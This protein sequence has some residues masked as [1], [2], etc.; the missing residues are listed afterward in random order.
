MTF[1]ESF[2]Q[3]C[4]NSCKPCLISSLFMC[5]VFPSLNDQVLSDRTFARLTIMNLSKRYFSHYICRVHETKSMTRTEHFL[6]EAVISCREWKHLFFEFQSPNEAWSAQGSPFRADP[7]DTRKDVRLALRYFPRRISAKISPLFTND[8]DHNEQ[9]TK[10]LFLSS[11]RNRRWKPHSQRKWDFEGRVLQPQSW[12]HTILCSRVGF[13]GRFSCFI[14]I[15][16]ER[17]KCFLWN[18]CMWDV[19][20]IENHGDQAT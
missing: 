1:R 4:I 13:K 15:A 5:L 8:S 18:E 14:N 20:L 2:C 6:F 19:S 10:L 12:K 3:D 17:Q 16:L 11:V 7:W 9:Q